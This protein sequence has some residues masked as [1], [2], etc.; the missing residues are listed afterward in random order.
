MTEKK[1]DPKSG[2]SKERFLRAINASKAKLNQEIQNRQEREAKINSTSK[3]V[4]NGANDEKKLMNNAKSGERFTKSKESELDFPAWAESRMANHR[5]SKG[6]SFPHV[7]FKAKTESTLRIVSPNPSS[8]EISS[9][10]EEKIGNPTIENSSNGNLIPPCCKTPLIND[11]KEED[12]KLEM[13]IL[14]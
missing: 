3:P 12:E 11:I 6:S 13:K 8:E 7:N 5:K 9:H 14:R 1:E 2:F 4:A 10:P